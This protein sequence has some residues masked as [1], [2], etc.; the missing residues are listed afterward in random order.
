MTL[1][2]NEQIF[3]APETALESAV[4]FQNVACNALSVVMRCFHFCLELLSF[5]VFVEIYSHF[6]KELISKIFH[7]IEIKN[8][9]LD[10][11]F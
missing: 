8:T 4:K 5:L 6:K 10:I 7:S 11:I 2:D 1:S 3:V 9:T